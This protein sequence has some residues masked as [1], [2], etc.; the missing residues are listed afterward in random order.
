[1]NQ[2]VDFIIGAISFILTIMV[3]S[4]LLG[5]NFFF[6]LAS[7]LLV[8][9]AS[10][11]TAALLI[12]KVIEPYLI[13]PIIQG[14]Y[15]QWLLVILPLLM[16]LLLIAMFFPRF[17]RL[18]SLPL[19]FLAGLVAAFTIVGVSFGTLVPQLGTLVERFNPDGLIVG[20]NPNYLKIA[21]AV[22]MLIGVVTSLFYFHFGL[23]RKK[24]NPE[25]RPKLIEAMAKIGQVFIGITLGALFAGVYSA[26]LLA[27][28]SRITMSRDFIMMLFGS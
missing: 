23:S 28:I 20:A 15:E 9:V 14:G 3:F 26:A 12:R 2:S 22:I 24:T 5:D 7:Y 13:T 17:S 16:C 6:R 21:D 25:M 4:Y 27:L 1:M 10:G 8:G 19:A 18:G 11:Y